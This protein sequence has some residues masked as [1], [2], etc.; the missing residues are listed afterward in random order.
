[1]INAKQN[2]ERE[3]LSNDV[4]AFLKNGGKI[5]K[6]GANDSAHNHEKIKSSRLTVNQKE[7]I[8]RQDRK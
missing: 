2:K 4:A 1:M 6:F 5:K 3:K 8:K 7:W